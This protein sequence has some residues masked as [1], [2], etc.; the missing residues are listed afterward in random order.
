METDQTQQNPQ[1]ARQPEVSFPEPREPQGKGSNIKIIIAVVGVILIL[2]AGGWFVLGN[3]SG[4][5]AT[6][7][8]TPNDGLSSFPTIAPTEMPSSTPTPTPEPVEKSEVKIEV[9]N[10]TGVPGE[11]GFLQGELED[12]G[13]EDITARNADSQDATETVATYSR[14]LSTAVADEI[15]AML[16]KVYKSVR[17]KKATI[18]GDYDVSIVTGPRADKATATSSAKATATATATAKATASPVGQ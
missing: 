5:S 11:A 2:L 3:N 14:D 6:P 16:E 18:S 1:I 8:P 17:T 15:T 9:L 7:S 13:F 12:L 10:G 4:E